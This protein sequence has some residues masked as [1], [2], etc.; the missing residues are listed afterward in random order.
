MRPMA[1][2]EPP[3]RLPRGTCYP[4]GHAQP[5]TTN[6]TLFATKMKLLPPMAA[7]TEVFEL[8]AMEEMLLGVDGLCS[9]DSVSRRSCALSAHRAV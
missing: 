5:V 2:T 7:R 9:R 4:L 8:S 3:E 1:R 6:P